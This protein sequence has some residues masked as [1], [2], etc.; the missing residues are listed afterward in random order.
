MV[1]G[2]GCLHIHQEYVVLVHNQYCSVPVL[3]M[4]E[5]LLIHVHIRLLLV[6]NFP[7]VG[8]LLTVLLVPCCHHSLVWP[9]HVSAADFVLSISASFPE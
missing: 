3:V 4:R 8:F 9:V 2:F 1:S 6:R 5:G 7:V